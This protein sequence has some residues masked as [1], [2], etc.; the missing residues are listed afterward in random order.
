MKMFS[1]IW[2]LFNKSEKRKVKL[3][4]FLMVLMSFFEILGLGS[5]MPFLTVLGDPSSIETNKYLKSLYHYLDFND[6]NSF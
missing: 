5:I 3:L 2:G 4:F 1:K 6:N